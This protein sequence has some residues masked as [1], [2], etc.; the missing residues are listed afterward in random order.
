M[1]LRKDLENWQAQWAQRNGIRVGA[2]PG[3]AASRVTGYVSELQE[4]LFEPLADRVKQQF[5]A[6]AG[7]GS[8][9]GPTR[10]KPGRKKDSITSKK[11]ASWVSDRCRL[12]RVRPPLV[13]QHIADLHDEPNNSSGSPEADSNLHLWV[14]TRRPVDFDGLRSGASPYWVY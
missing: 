14:A 5:I 4:N 9:S 7:G 12:P 1:S 3:N 10:K 6:G 8:L 11:L 13:F 2:P